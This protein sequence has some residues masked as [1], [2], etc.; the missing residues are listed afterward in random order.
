MLDESALRKPG[1]TEGPRIVL[2]DGQPW[3]FPH[4]RLSLYPVRA[5]DG[6]ITAGGGMGYGVDYADLVD[7]LVDCDPGDTNA[8]LALQF[9]MAASL[10]DRNYTLGDRDLRRLLAIDLA[11]SEC[12]TRWAQIN[13]VLLGRPPK[14]SADGSAIL[15]LPTGSP[16]N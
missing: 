6:R 16:G 4:P 7:Q 11:D 14:P 3:A 10:L 1:F 8:R 5:A 12:E 13:Q 9:Q 15:S 2:G